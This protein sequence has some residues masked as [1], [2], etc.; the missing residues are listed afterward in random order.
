MRRF[1]RPSLSLDGTWDLVPDTEQTRGPGSLPAGVPVQVPGCW[2]AQLDRPYRIITAWYRR[3]FELP[4][5]WSP[6]APALVRFGAVM[7][8]A[9]AWLNGQPIGEHEG[10]YTEFTLPTANLLRAGENELL[11]RV[12]NPLN[13][14]ADY[15]AL[16]VERTLLAQEWAPELPL[17]EAPHGKQTWYSSQSG[18]WR[19]VTLEQ[20]EERWFDAVRFLPDLPGETA[21]LRWEIRSTASQP[22]DLWLRVEVHD[23]DGRPLPEVLEDLDQGRRSGSLR[24]PVPEPQPWAPAT[25]RRYTARVT[26][27]EDGRPCDAVEVR[28][29]MRSIAVRDGRML[30]N[31]EPFH[32]R[33]ALDQDLYPETISGPPSHAFLEEQLRR[34][35]EMGLNLLRVHIKSPDPDYVELAD[36][37]GMLLWCE[38]PNWTIFSSAA[39]MRGRRTLEEMVVACGNHPSIIAWTIINEDWGTDLRYEARDR[40]WLRRMVDW[41]RG[42]DPTRLIVDNSACDTPT[43]PNFHLQ[44]DLADF[45]TYFVSPDNANRWA[46]WVEEYARRPAFLWSPYQDAAPTG[47]E[48]LVVSEFGSW[49]LPD[50]A[51]LMGPDGSPPWWFGTGQT[52][53]LPAGISSRFRRSGLRRVWPDLSALAQGT[54]WHQFENLQYEIAELRRHAPIAGYVITELTDATWE[55]NGLLTLDRH[56]KVFHER[57]AAIN[58]PDVA[59]T[60]LQR[61]DLAGGTVL[62]VPFWVAAYGDPATSGVIEWWLDPEAGPARHGHVPIP[63]W[64]RHTAVAAGMALIDVPSVERV[65]DARLRW[66]LRDDAGRLRS[67]DELRVAILPSARATRPLDVAVHDPLAMW[68][69]RERVETLGHR[70][71]IRRAADVLVASVV[72]DLVV[73]HA[74][75]GGAVVVLVRTQDAVPASAD[76]ARRVTV[77]LRRSPHTGWPGQ[78]SPWEG[79]WVTA[80]SWMTPELQDGL[81]AR[82]PLDFAYTEVLPDHV[83]LGYEP[84][85]HREEVEAGMFVGWVHTPAAIEWRFPQGKGTITLTTF[86]VAPESGPVA[87]HLLGRLIERAAASVGATGAGGGG[88]SR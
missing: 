68:S 23:P 81:P 15:P 29:G 42:L 74:E 30:L 61:R 27:L 56:P 78:R 76:L 50:P 59:V 31:G 57:L 25:P 35:Q 7:Y 69:I 19:S 87:S 48:P 18:L 73:E 5:G 62:E 79:D 36:E 80:F 54:Q 4:D 64:P 2:E 70:L 85:R 72:D 67:G 33:G 6:G 53:Y 16:A 10:G 17:T 11:V 46:T 8:G 88:W 37:L 58:A 13:A 82:A 32:M 63:D 44:S 38:L 65:T 21:E 39:A 45:H 40:L 20:I 22:G 47:E 28:F 24:V 66:V 77:H 51:R 34:A 49:G 84:E 43:T 14:I 52:Y 75:A 83:L 26:L 9:T 60:T 41:L 1:L 86:R 3:R 55:A 71:A 12:T